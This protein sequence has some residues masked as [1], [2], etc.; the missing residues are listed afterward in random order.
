MNGETFNFLEESPILT[1][2]ESGH[3]KKFHKI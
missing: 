3:N 2:I 1:P